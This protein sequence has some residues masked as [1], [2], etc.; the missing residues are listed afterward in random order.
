[1]EA[2]I[3]GRNR[4]WGPLS[5]CFLL[6]LEST[7]AMLLPF[8][9]SFGWQGAVTEE[10]PP[11]RSLVSPALGPQVLAATWSFGFVTKKTSQQR[12]T[13]PSWG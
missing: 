8:S 2:R 9:G 3:S 13:L 10:W 5:F 12:K 4:V 1:M 11:G 7:H 6:P